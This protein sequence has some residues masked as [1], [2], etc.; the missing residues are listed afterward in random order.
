MLGAGVV[1]AVGESVGA[2]EWRRKCCDA[3]INELNLRLRRRGMM[4]CCEE[5]EA[6]DEESK[7]D[8]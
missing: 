1:A 5:A 4:P 8:E 6:H 7:T 2:T 3:K